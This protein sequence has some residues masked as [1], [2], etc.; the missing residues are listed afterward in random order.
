MLRFR[1]VLRANAAVREAY[2]REKLRI[3]EK[4]DWDK[5]AYSLA[6]GPFIESVLDRYGP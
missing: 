4:V 1:E 6:K 5:G 3:A 2:A